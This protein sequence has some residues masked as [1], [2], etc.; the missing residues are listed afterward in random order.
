MRLLSSSSVH[1]P[2]SGSRTTQELGAE[3]VG[4]GTPVSERPLQVGLLPHHRAPQRTPGPQPCG[5]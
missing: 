1:L 4:G 3:G 5:R 2:P